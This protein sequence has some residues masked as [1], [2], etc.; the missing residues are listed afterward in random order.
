M[1]LLAFEI[2]KLRRSRAFIFINS[3]PLV[4]LLITYISFLS[5]VD[6]GD[7]EQN[8]FHYK[9]ES[10]VV[11][12]PF[13]VYQA[14]YFGMMF[15]IVLPI[16]IAA[17]FSFSS[18]LDLKNSAFR[19]YANLNRQPFK[20]HLIKFASVFLFFVTAM[21]A[22]Y[23][24][25]MITTL[26]LPDLKKDL[27]YDGFDNYLSYSGL[28]L[29]KITFLAIP[30]FLLHY[31]ISLKMTSP[32]VNILVA[33][34][35]LLITFG[36]YNNTPYFIFIKGYSDSATYFLLDIVDIEEINWRAMLFSFKYNFSGGVFI[37]ITIGF[38]ISDLCF[39]WW[40]RVFKNRK[41]IQ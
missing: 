2:Q 12:N 30:T 29:M 31:W 22:S 7:L 14:R 25:L 11:D 32:T 16:Y 38:I 33:L 35:L 37:A 15:F 21:V 40:N 36:V 13:Y 23:L 6:Q 1:N 5:H 34:V 3:I 24:L 20:I 27:I 10:Y 8:F 19:L 17:L 39:N 9:M 28:L 41:Y 18:Y 4:T 26:T